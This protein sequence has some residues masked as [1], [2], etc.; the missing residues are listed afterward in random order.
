MSSSPKR[1]SRA[2]PDSVGPDPAAKAEER[3]IEALDYCVQ[4]LVEAPPHTADLPAAVLQALCEQH[5]RYKAQADYR[6]LKAQEALLKWQLKK[7]EEART[8]AAS[9]EP[10]PSAAARGFGR[11]STNQTL[12]STMELAPTLTESAPP[13]A[14]P[15]APSQPA[16]TPPAPAPP[17]DAEAS[18]NYR[19]PPPPQGESPP[20]A[21]ARASKYKSKMIH[22]AF[23]RIQ[24]DEGSECSAASA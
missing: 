11:R 24:L 6:R 3:L 22:A 10:G 20:L 2:F 4:R 21:R 15:T 9:A 18:P 13:S 8:G 16:S 1:R 12:Q 23:T 17:A 19:R 7:L 14:P 5:P